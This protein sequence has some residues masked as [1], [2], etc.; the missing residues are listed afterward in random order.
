MP[1]DS[2][3]SVSTK[4]STDPLR[5]RYR[6]R[7]AIYSDFEYSTWTQARN[8]S[9]PPD[10]GKRFLPELWNGFKPVSFHIC[11]NPVSFHLCSRTIGVVRGLSERFAFAAGRITITPVRRFISGAKSEFSRGLYRDRV[12]RLTGRSRGMAIFKTIHRIDH[13]RTVDAARL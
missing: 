11:L 2:S 12:S 13:S 1:V 4:H 10:A 7:L 3:I 5:L 6:D 8:F 9:V